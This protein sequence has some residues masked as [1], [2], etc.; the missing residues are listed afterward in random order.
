MCWFMLNSCVCITLVDAVCESFSAPLVYRLQNTLSSG[1]C[2]FKSR[3]Q[4]RRINTPGFGA[5][6]DAAFIFKLPPRKCVGNYV[7]RCRNQASAGLPADRYHSVEGGAARH[8][9]D[10]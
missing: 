5:F 7:I 4:S 6:G 1:M 3:T 8:T 9:A 2:Y 10:K